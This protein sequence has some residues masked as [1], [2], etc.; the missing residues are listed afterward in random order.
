[1]SAEVVDSWEVIAQQEFD[2]YNRQWGN[3]LA[4]Y[5]EE[6]LTARIAFTKFGLPPYNDEQMVESKLFAQ[7]LIQSTDDRKVNLIEILIVCKTKENV[8]KVF[9]YKFE[10]QKLKKTI[11]YMDYTGRIYTTWDDWLSNNHLPPCQMKYPVDGLYPTTQVTPSPSGGTGQKIVNGLDT[12]VMVAG[13]GLVGVAILSLWFPPAAAAIP[14]IMAAE[15][16]VATYGATRSAFQLHDRRVHE[17]SISL[18]DAEARSMWLGIGTSI[19]G[20]SCMASL[21]KVAKAAQAGRVLTSGERVFLNALRVSTISLSG[22][23]TINSSANLGYKIY[24]GKNEWT[25]LEV[26]QLSVSIF[27][28]TRSVTNFKSA[29]QMLKAEQRRYVAS[30]GCKFDPNM[31]SEEGAKYVQRMNR[32]FENSADNMHLMSKATETVPTRGQESHLGK[33]TKKH[34]ALKE[35]TPG[36]TPASRANTRSL[37]HR[38][39][40][41]KAST[42]G[43]IILRAKNATTNTTRELKIKDFKAMSQAAQLAFLHDADISFKSNIDAHNHGTS[44]LNAIITAPDRN[45]EVLMS[46]SGVSR[47][48]I[49]ISSAQVGLGA[50]WTGTEFTGFRDIINNIN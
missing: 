22:A 13:V 39:N 43:E 44:V 25:W 19:A 32:A 48:T 21:G 35:R 2:E 24:E 47:D 27:F 1:M 34:I 5:D 18:A 9:V 8:F 14:Y 6:S 26:S 12:T 49:N 7:K 30:Q 29:G 38:A 23:C 45:V 20:I 15:G 41:L 50:Q 40:M 11:R 37:E 17:Q 31:R 3:K 4:Y 46:S 28:L 33:A 42:D 36:S 10:H 16:T